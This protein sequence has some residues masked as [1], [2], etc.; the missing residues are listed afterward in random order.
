MAAIT[1]RHFQQA[2]DI[3][4]AILDH[5]WTSELPDWAE[6]QNREPFTFLG[7]E[8]EPWNPDYLRAVWTA[9]AFILLFSRNNDRFDRGRFLRACGLAWPAPPY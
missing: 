4:R 8:G 2:A 1:K 6:Y 5:E 3:V 7:D 9:E